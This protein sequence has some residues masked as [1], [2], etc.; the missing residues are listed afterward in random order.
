M[1]NSHLKYLDILIRAY[2]RKNSSL[3]GDYV[4]YF[5]MIV[6]LM[7]ISFIIIVATIRLLGN[8]HIYPDAVAIA[9]TSAPVPVPALAP[10][11]SLSNRVI[12]QSTYPQIDYIPS[13]SFGKNQPLALMPNYDNSVYETMGLF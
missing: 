3:L 11:K 8:S 10:V 12:P 2:T 4:L 9:P 5:S 7:I 1:E 6:S 13:S